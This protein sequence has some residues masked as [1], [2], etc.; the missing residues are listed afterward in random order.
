LTIGVTID[1]I[2]AEVARLAHG[3][4]GG[5]AV[6]VA[7]A[8]AGAVPAAS[9]ATGGQGCAE[10]NAVK[11]VFPAA[12]KIGFTRRGPV[13]FQGQR[14]LKF[15][16]WCAGW[17]VE[18]QNIGPRG[19]VDSYVDVS[20][21]L[22]RTAAQTLAP[23]HEPAYGLIGNLGD[24]GKVN[25]LP[26]GALSVIRNVFVSTTSS[27]LPSDANGFPD[28]AGGPDISDPALMK[29]HRAIHAQVV[30]LR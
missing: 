1:I 2:S 12:K 29:I 8:V 19:D 9:A 23:L 16:G 18:Y 7:V 21:T 27:Q 20:V 14:G 13:K 15:P 6:L 10:R 28:G 26:G 30:Q 17:W 25:F 5:A 4:I 3:L 11:A 24:G 22:Y